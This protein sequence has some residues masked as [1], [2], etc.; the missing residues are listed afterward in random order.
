[1]ARRSEGGDHNGPDR[2]GESENTTRDKET[3]SAIGSRREILRSRNLNIS[4]KK[5]ILITTSDEE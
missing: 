3:T 5:R 2:G 1:M 4:F